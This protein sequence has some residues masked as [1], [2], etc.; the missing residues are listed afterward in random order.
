[1]S[2]TSCT[3]T[4]AKLYLTLKLLN[5]IKLIKLGYYDFLLI[6]TPNKLLILPI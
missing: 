5:R 6:N 2:A 1:M 4:E 3:V